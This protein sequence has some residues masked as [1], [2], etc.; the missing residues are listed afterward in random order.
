M[1]ILPPFETSLGR[2]GL[3]IC[4]DVSP[5]VMQS[6]P[7]SILIVDSYDS[8]KSALRS[9]ARTRISSHILPLSLSQQAERIGK[10]YFVH[11]QLRPSLT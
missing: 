3:A 10:L 7:S 9:S 6:M 11:E 1:E 4:F 8:L 5:S 2:V